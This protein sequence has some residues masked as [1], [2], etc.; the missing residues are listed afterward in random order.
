MKKESI[1][2]Y[3]ITFYKN[4]ENYLNKHINPI[5]GHY[6]ERLWCYMFTKNEPFW[7]SIFDV[8][9]TK[10]ERSRFKYIYSIFKNLKENNLQ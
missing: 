9:F 2:K 10:L 5:E 3:D 1:R 4:I 6:M 7:E 8:L